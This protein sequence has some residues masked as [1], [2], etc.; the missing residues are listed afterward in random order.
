MGKMHE[1]LAVESSVAGNYNRDL[2]ETLKVFDKPD[3]F[4]RTVTTK[5]FL[6]DE[7]Q[8]FNTSTTSEITTTVKKRL[9][10][11]KGSVTKFFDLV[12]QKDL[13]NQASKADIVI[14][15]TVIANNVPATT[16]LMLEARLQDLRKAFD[17]MPTLQAG[18]SWGRDESQG[19]WKNNETQISF[20][21][22]KTMKP[23]ILAPATEQH[24]A[25]VEKVFEDVNVAKVARDTY[26]GMLSSEEKATILGRLDDLLQGVKKARQRANNTDVVT[27]SIGDN[28]FTYLYKDVVNK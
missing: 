17:K 20:S 25:Q 11:F 1:L 2:E 26:S 12:L 5:T 13:T 4:T 9:D 8:K 14:G 24:P 10:W 22:K 6:A 3:L 23:V 18:I 27:G 28:I 7:D 16:L 19:L 21:T 15:D